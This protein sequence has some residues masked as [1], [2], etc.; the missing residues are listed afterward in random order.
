MNI[1]ILSSGKYGSRIVNHIAK[2]FSSSIVGIHEVSEDL[3]E[4]IDDVSI[5]MPDNLP[6]ADLVIAVGL[7]GDI[8]LLTLLVAEGT[9]AK[10]ILVSVHDPKGMPPGLMQEIKETADDKGLVVV[11][12]KPFCILQPMGDPFID[13]FAGKL[14][15]PVMEIEFDDHVKSVKV[16]RDAPCGCTTFIAEELV[17]APVEE[18]EHVADI[19]FHN[20][21]CQASMSVDRNFGDTILHIAGYQS[22]EAVRRA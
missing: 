5:Y 8:N 9:G 11:F 20:Y 10:S 12:A 14:G 3:P 7:I 21:P 6:E 16:V 22:K 2:S 15:K 17:G 1:Y 4:F 13:E 19:K 18:A